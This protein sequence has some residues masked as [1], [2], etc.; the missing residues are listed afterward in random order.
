[1][2]RILFRGEKLHLQVS[3]GQNT[4]II[5]VSSRY[6]PFNCT[7]NWSLSRLHATC[8]W[9]SGL[10][11]DLQLRA[12]TICLFGPA[13]LKLRPFCCPTPP[14]PAPEDTAVGRGRQP[15]PRGG[16]WEGKIAPTRFQPV[17]LQAFFS[18]EY[19]TEKLHLFGGF[20]IFKI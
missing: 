20:P 15:P 8:Q 16:R 6:R 9:S 3:L 7:A 12:G 13:W 11:R 2:V 10:S 18:L 14:N 4:A 17:I 19:T 5:Y 1:M